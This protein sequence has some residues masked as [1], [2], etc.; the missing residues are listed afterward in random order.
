MLKRMEGIT[1]DA[2]TRLLRHIRSIKRGRP[3]G[4]E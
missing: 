1:P 3:P 4:V 2:I